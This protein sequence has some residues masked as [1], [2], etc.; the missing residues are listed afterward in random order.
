M[1]T[2]LSRRTLLKVGAIA[3]VGLAVPGRSLAHPR[4]A[5]ALPRSNRLRKFIQP[6]RNP[7]FGG[8]PL[9][10]PDTDRERWWQPG[11]THYTMDIAQ[12]TD[13]LHPDLPNPTRLWGFGQN[14]VFR[15]LG[16]IIAAKRGSPVQ[17][18][19]RNR[20]PSKHIL[21]VDR[22]IM[23]TEGQDNR[24][25]VHLHGG[26]VPWT[27]DGGPLAWWDP[28]GHIGPGFLNNTVLDVPRPR[29]DQAEYYYPND[30]SARLMWYHDH[31]IGITRLNAYA[32]LATAY[33]MSD[34]YELS[35]V[36][37]AHLPGPLDPR[38][39]YLVFQDKIVRRRIHRGRR[40]DLVADH[41]RLA[42]RR[43][44]VRP[45]VR[46][47]LW[48]LAPDAPAGPPPDPSC[49]PEFFADTMLVNGT[50]YPYLEVEQRQYRFRLLNACQARFLNP[51]LVYASGT[52]PP[53]DAE[54]DATKAGPAFVQFGTE[55]GFL[56][57]PTMRQWA[58]PD[59][60]APR[61]RRACRPHRRLPRRALRLDAHPLQRRSRALPDGRRPER[62]LPGQPE[63]AVRPGSAIGPNTRTLLQFRVKARIGAA[64]APISLPAHAAPDRSVPGRPGSRQSD[65]DPA[66]CPR[67][68]A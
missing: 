9:A 53:Y 55:G 37:R 43:P 59:A 23:G 27:S 65:Q 5:C 7:V 63:H 32:G 19:F 68:D 20:L 39:V 11:V 26:F 41:A 40:P 42:T 38:T 18:T 1:S 25:D 29:P 66:R 45:R 46:P 44:L 50:V 21:P 51:R 47:G 60:A 61:T 57:A 12:Y 34:D 58:R 6:L 14:G 17:I 52:R 64:D 8:I 54:P 36:G 15:N 56:P 31:A 10:A 35:L 30:Q 33:V 13:Q 22:S 4:V 67:P 24:T 62:L 48:G 16:G 49:V 3:G 2:Q 28:N